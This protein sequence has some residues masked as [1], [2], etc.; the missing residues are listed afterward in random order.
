MSSILVGVI[1]SEVWSL[2]YSSVL[3]K[4]LF[5]DSPWRLTTGLNVFHNLGVRLWVLSC[6]CECT[7]LVV[8]A[9]GRQYLKF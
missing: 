7:Y 1:F 2:G 4:Y 5:L 8:A 3:M 6:V 9:L